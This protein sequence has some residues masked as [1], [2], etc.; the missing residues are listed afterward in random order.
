MSSEEKKFNKDLG[1]QFVPFW[2]GLIHLVGN[3][4][5]G[6]IIRRSDWSNIIQECEQFEKDFLNTS[7]FCES[8]T[9][10]GMPSFLESRWKQA[11]EAGINDCKKM[12]QDNDFLYLYCMEKEKGKNPS[13]KKLLWLLLLLLI[14]PIIIIIIL[15]WIRVTPKTQYPLQKRIGNVS[16]KG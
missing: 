8:C 2:N 5:K 3:I 6:T 13:N 1:K 4:E 12:A 15:Y 10:Y 9:F 7:A 11:K 16:I 14:I